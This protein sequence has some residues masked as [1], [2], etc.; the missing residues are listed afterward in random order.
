V[1]TL[2]IA[3]WVCGGCDISERDSRTIVQLIVR[4]SDEDRRGRFWGGGCDIQVDSKGTIFQVGLKE[5]QKI[6]R[7]VQ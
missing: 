6:I 1:S 4:Q 5:E 3:V 7:Q 2:C